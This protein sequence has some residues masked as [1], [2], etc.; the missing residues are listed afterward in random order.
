MSKALNDLIRRGYTK[1]AQG[2]APADAY[3]ACP[4]CGARIEG[5]VTL[6][7]PRSGVGPVVAHFSTCDCAIEHRER[8][9]LEAGHPA[10]AQPSVAELEP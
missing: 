1:S 5:L 2:L 8:R 6:W 10:I 4:G 7:R 3:V 9:A